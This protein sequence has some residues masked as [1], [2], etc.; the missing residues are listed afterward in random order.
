M[1]AQRSEGC[2]F[3]TYLAQTHGVI[4]EKKKKKS[5]HSS[6]ETLYGGA[7]KLFR[8]SNKYM[9]VRGTKKPLL[10]KQRRKKICF[11]QKYRSSTSGCTHLCQIDKLFCQTVLSKCFKVPIYGK[12]TENYPQKTFK[13]KTVYL[14]SQY[15][16]TPPPRLQSLSLLNHHLLI[17][18]RLVTVELVA[19]QRSWT[20]GGWTT[21]EWEPRHPHLPCM[22]QQTEGPGCRKT[23]P[24]HGPAGRHH[25]LT[26]GHQ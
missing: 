25:A 7:R 1:F 17:F 24:V 5:F 22:S 14:Y 23:S 2:E 9:H 3:E 6:T 18:G 20:D 10:H 13:K 19:P 12:N 8:N 26:R 21:P 4:S 15:G 16:S 11:H